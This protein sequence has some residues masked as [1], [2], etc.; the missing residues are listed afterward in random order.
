MPGSGQ[1]PFPVD[2]KVTPAADQS[3]VTS[4][5]GKQLVGRSDGA[6][7][8]VVTAVDPEGRY[9]EVST[10][11]TVQVVRQDDLSIEPPTVSVR[12]GQPTPQLAVMAAGEDGLP[13]QVPAELESMDPNVLAPDPARPGQFVA[14]ALGGTQIRAR[15]RGK[16][17]HADVTVT[18]ERFVQVDTKPETAGTDSFTVDITVLAAKSE[19]PLE[20]RVY[21]AG[22]PPQEAWTP[23]RMQEDGEHQEVQLRSPQMKEGPRSTVYQ[24]IIESRDRAGGTVQQ[25]PYTFQL[26]III[27][28]TDK[29]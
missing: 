23:A 1:Q 13:Y 29:F 4:P 5:D 27:K 7:Q 18:G 20:Y 6:T 12:V 8:V 24:L 17:A 2:Y 26:G 14:K 16:E 15:Y 11:A 21:G 10:T 25:F 28:E 3:I 19:G 22:Q 9:G